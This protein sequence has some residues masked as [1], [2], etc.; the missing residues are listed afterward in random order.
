MEAECGASIGRVICA[1]LRGRWG[2]TSEV[3]RIALSRSWTELW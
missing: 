3:V 1:R 2:S